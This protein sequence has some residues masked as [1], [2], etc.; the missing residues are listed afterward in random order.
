MRPLGWS[1]SRVVAGVALGAWAAVFW[2]LLISGRSALYVSS[3]TFWVIPLGAIVLTAAAI[4]RLATARAPAS[5]PLTRRDA[6]GAGLVILPV[7]AVLVLPPSALGSYAASRRSTTSGGFVP[8]SEEQIAEGPL[9]LVDVAAAAWSRDAMR[10]LVRR[11]GSTVDFVGFVTRDPGAPE[12]EFVLTR[13]I[14]SCCVADA[15]SVQVR[16]VGAP[17]GR[18]GEDQWV[19][20]RGTFY[21]VG[22]EMLVDAT[23]IT[24]VPRPAHPYLNP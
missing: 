22:R 6:W 24:A 23:E 12:D 15:L 4:G 21:P 1:P 19:R 17:P 3:R 14:I 9:E 13:F 18:F 20:V 5:E 16:V 8:A 10:A 7:V 2:V 11:A